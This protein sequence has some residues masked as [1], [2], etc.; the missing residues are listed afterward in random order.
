MGLGVGKFHLTGRKAL[1]QP[2]H[3]VV[4][5]SRAV[6]DGLAIEHILVLSVH[7]ITQEQDRK[8]ERGETA[9]H[10]FI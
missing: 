5:L 3:G 7:R 4:R 2:L 6:A 1:P 10:R 8:Q 9:A